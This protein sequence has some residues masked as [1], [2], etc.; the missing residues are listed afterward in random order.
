LQE[1]LNVT[2]SNLTGLKKEF[3]VEQ[4]LRIKAESGLQ[5]SIEEP[6][7]V[8]AAFETERATFE[9]KKAALIK[10]A[11]DAEGQLKAVTKELDWLKCHI[12]QMTQATFGKLLFEYVGLTC[13]VIVVVI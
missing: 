13:L 10:R 9:T 7:K 11:E 3:G 4:T 5:Y 6:K 2:E 12:T 8:K 1:K